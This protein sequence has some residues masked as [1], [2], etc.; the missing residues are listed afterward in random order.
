MRELLDPPSSDEEDYPSPTNSGSKSSL[1][2]NHEG[3]VFGFHS[4]AHSLRD[5][6]PS[7]E[8]IPY[9]WQ[10][11][12]TS[13]APLISLFHRPTLKKLYSEATNNLD[14]L[15]KNTEVVLFCVYYAAVT[16]MDCTQCNTLLS[17][18]RDVLI[19]RFRFAV[20]QAVARANLLNSQS[21]LVLQGLVLF[22]FCVRLQDHSRYVWTMTALVV[23]I[24]QGLGVHRDGT[25]FGLA[26][27][28]TEIRRRLWWH[29]CI[30]DFRAA[31]DHGC[32]PMTHE[33]FFDAK[34]PSNVNDDDISPEMESPP[35]EHVGC[36]DLTFT[37]I[38][39]EVVATARK[40]YYAVPHC[41]RDPPLL[42]LAEREDLIE[43]LNKRLEEKY[44]QYCDMSVPIY[45]VCATL[46]RLIVAKFWL[47]AHQPLSNTLREDEVLAQETH[48]RLF[49]T[50]IE[51]VEFSRLIDTNE[52]TMK[53][54][55][56]FRTHMQLSV[57]AFILSEL[58]V[59]YPCP[60][61]DRAWR[62]VNSVYR[63]WQIQSETKRHMLWRAIRKLKE[64][65]TRHYQTQLQ[66]L[67]SEMTLDNQVSAPMTLT[68]LAQP[69]SHPP[70]SPSN[71]DIS[72]NTTQGDYDFISPLDQP[73]SS[74]IDNNLLMT[75]VNPLQDDLL[76]ASTS[77]W[78]QRGAPS[79]QDCPEFN[80]DCPDPLM[81][82]RTSWDDW[83]Q[84][85][86]DFQ[87]DVAQGTEGH[88]MVQNAAR[89]N[90]WF[91]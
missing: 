33:A 14:N 53:W 90:E 43:K 2:S 4:L 49:L 77:A 12:N 34:L 63:V 24:A 47:L 74:T 89:M 8:Q 72:V 45:W 86:R 79:L 75:T 58:C 27:F 81:A 64:R 42:S 6:H 65:A 37:L 22:L 68:H 15:N 41:P 85:I 13:V 50:A 1:S 40:L 16:S 21:I 57:L 88:T 82:Q 20:E 70:S 39:C 25:V 73:Q 80:S 87:M 44:V 3:F 55:W 18:N 32:D 66:Q 19:S 61:V 9:I 69:I 83:D 76:A 26:P 29:I 51:V 67:A 56:L 28:E 10:T 23:R 30:L 31:E 7:P 38:R 35:Q 59:R 5:F 48:N 54:S 60:V 62:A 52:N 91:E 46:S 17:E 78:L 11:Y 84:V 71:P 36:T